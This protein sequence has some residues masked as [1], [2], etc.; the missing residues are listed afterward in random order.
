VPGV[1]STA[2]NQDGTVNST[3]NPASAGSYLTIYATGEGLTDGANISGQ[4][5][6]AP[7]PQP[8]LPV[9]ATVSGI[10]AQIVWA[11][12]APGL[13]GLLQ[14]N[15]IVPGPYLPSGAAPLQLMVGTAVSPLT[16]IWVQ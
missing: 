13:V 15:L 16:T 1:F 3:A 9:S 8:Q 7:Y 5:A 2:V 14:V 6:T 10:S 12:S 4:A 11:G